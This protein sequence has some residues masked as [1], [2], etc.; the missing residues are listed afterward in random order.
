M[1]IRWNK[2]TWYSKLLAV[3]VFAATFLVAFNLGMLAGQT[4]PQSTTVNCA[5]AR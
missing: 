5:S 2:V 3:V 4:Y 1:A